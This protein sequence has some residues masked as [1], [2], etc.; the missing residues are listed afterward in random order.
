MI[1]YFVD[2]IVAALV[3]RSSFRV[4][5][6]VLSTC[7]IFLWA[8]FSFWHHE[9][10]QAHLEFSLPQPWNP[11]FFQGALV[12]CIGERC[13]D[14]KTWAPIC[15]H[16]SVSLSLY[17][18]SET[19]VTLTPG[20]PVQHR[21][22]RLSPPRFSIYTSISNSEKLS[23]YGLQYMYSFAQSYNTQSGSRISNPHPLRNTCSD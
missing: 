5:P 2:L 21:R 17:I 20:I 13:L 18:C 4:G 14:T 1:I 22:V 19:W 23:S 11:S 15:I 3:I 6:C 12:P 16:T 7:P 10:F 9:M 8:L